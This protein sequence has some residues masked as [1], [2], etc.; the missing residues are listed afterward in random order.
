LELTGKPQW[1][2]FCLANRSLTGHG[3]SFIGEWCNELV[4]LMTLDACAEETCRFYANCETD[5][6]GQAQCVCPTSCLKVHLHAN[7]ST[8]SYI[9]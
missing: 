7:N 5:D 2:N 4:V 6:T 9:H 8:L 3:R 1:E